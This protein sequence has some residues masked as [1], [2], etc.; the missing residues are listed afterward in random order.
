MNT[1]TSLLKKSYSLQMFH[2]VRK[3]TRSRVKE[4]FQ[5]FPASGDLE[6]IDKEENSLDSVLPSTPAEDGRVALACVSCRQ[7]APFFVQNPNNLLQRILCRQANPL[8]N[9]SVRLDD[10]SVL[11]GQ[12][13][14]REK[15]LFLDDEGRTTTTPIPRLASIQLH[16]WPC[17]VQLLRWLLDS[18]TGI[19][20]V[21]LV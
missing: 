7:A 3:P 1:L 11:V 16:H 12:Q 10:N 19:L 13:K 6:S 20:W 5:N 9:D 15:T 14:A 21:K 2:K 18:K 8:E 4:P 17:S